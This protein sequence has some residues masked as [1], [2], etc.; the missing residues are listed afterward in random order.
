MKEKQRER[1]PPMAKP[2]KGRKTELRS[3]YSNWSAIKHITAVAQKATKISWKEKTPKIWNIFLA[4]ADDASPSEKLR[5]LT[6]KASSWMGK[7]LEGEFD[8]I[9]DGKNEKTDFCNLKVYNDFF[10]FTRNCVRERSLLLV[11][12]SS[13]NDFSRNFVLESSTYSKVE[14]FPWFGYWRE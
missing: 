9:K 7:K 2:W 10:T 13:S 4:Y 5:S 1:Q 14:F 11:A 6:G 8:G 12:R 3:F